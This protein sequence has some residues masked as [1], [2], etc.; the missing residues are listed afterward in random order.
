MSISS[1]SSPSTVQHT[2]NNSLM[3]VNKH[4]EFIF[5]A[6]GTLINAYLDEIITTNTPKS[7]DPVKNMYFIQIV[8]IVLAILAYY[9]GIMLNAYAFLL[10]S[11]YAG[12]IGSSLYTIATVK[13]SNTCI[14]KEL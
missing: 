10:Y 11:N 1:I 3:Y 9:A 7:H 14:T 12:I 5:V 4:F 6:F 13:F 8:S 2:I